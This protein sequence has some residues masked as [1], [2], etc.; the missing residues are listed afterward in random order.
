MHNVLFVYKQV[1][2]QF[3]KKGKL[4]PFEGKA[5]HVLS[6]DEKPGIQAITTTYGALLSNG[7]HGAIKRDHEYKRLGTVSLLD[8]IDLQ[9]GEAIPLVSDTH[10]SKDYIAFLKNLNGRYFH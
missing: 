7:E 2:L 9:T 4:I 3:D 1:S 10:N 5:T 6:Y 8:G